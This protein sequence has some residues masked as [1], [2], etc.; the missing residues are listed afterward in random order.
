MVI[1]HQSFS[2]GFQAIF[3]Y[4]EQFLQFAACGQGPFPVREF[5]DLKR[6]IGLETC[7]VTSIKNAR[8]RIVTATF[9]AGKNFGDNR[10]MVKFF[11][12]LPVK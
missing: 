11:V 9:K 4:P 7:Y 8:K 1:F 10:G 2:Y 3:K 5:I 12:S 6:I